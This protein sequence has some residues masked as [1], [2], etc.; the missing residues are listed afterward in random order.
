MQLRNTVVAIKAYEKVKKEKHA[1]FHAKTCGTFIHKKISL[2]AR[3]TWLSLLFYFI[4]IAVVRGVG[5]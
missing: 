2:V 1:N 3:Y 5:R 4:V